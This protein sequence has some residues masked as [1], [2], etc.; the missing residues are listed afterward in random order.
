MMPWEKPQGISIERTLVFG[1][2][3]ILNIMYS[4]ISLQIKSQA[5]ID[6]L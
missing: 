4:S 3:K 6:E 2:D 5:E 1:V